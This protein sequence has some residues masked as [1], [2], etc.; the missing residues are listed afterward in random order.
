LN[1]SAEMPQENIKVNEIIKA[2]KNAIRS[3]FVRILSDEQKED[4]AD[5]LYVL[6][7]AALVTSKV[8]KAAWPVKTAR[9]IAE[10]LL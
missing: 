2:Q 4:L 6:F 9:K 10:K 8:Y 1:I 3:L 5:E 7:D